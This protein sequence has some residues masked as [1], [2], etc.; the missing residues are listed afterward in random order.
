MSKNLYWKILLIV[1]LIGLAAFYVY[2]PKD[3]LKLGLDLAGGTSLVYEIDTQD[4]NRSERKGLAQRMIPILLRR[5]D[6][7]NVANIVMRPQGDTRIEIQ[8]P[9]SSAETRNKR[10]D[11]EKALQSLEK[12]NVNLLVIR[13][14]L[15]ADDASRQEAFS[16][17]AGDSAERKEILENLATAYDARKAKQDERNS[18]ASQMAEIKEKIKSAGLRDDFVEAMAPQWSKLDVGARTEAIAKFVETNKPADEGLI[19]TLAGFFEDNKKLV[20]EYVGAYSK[21][22]EVVN[23]L[24]GPETGLNAQYDQAVA[25]LSELNLSMVQMMDVLDLSPDS[26]QRRTQFN[27]F[28]LKFPKRETKINAVISTFDEYRKDRGR[29]DDPE[30]LKRMLKGAGVLEFRILPASNDG[31]IT[32]G[33]LEGYKESLQTKGPKQALGGKYVW[34]Q[35]EEPSDFPT[36]FRDIGQPAVGTFGDKY[37]VLASNRQNECMLR[38]SGMKEWKLRRAYPTTDSKTGRRAIGFTHDEI[39]AGMFYNVTNSNIG[40]PLCIL[41][42]GVAISS[43][44]IN[45]AIRSSGVITGDFTETEVDDMVNKLN[46]G[47]F[48]ARLSEVPISE[49][50]IGATIGVDNRN[51]GIGAGLIG[52]AA[53]GV[54]MLVYYLLAGSIADVALL[55]NM[56]FVLGMMAMFRGTFTLPG[57]AAIILTIGM[58]VD[59]NVLIFERIREEQDRGSSL[60]AAIATGYQRAFRTI[61]DANVTTLITALILYMVASEEIK[62]FAIVLMLGIASSMFTALFVTRMIFDF[63]V[64]KRVIK[65]H[66]L[67]L[68]L[69]RSPQVNWMGIRGV[70]FTIS[71]VLIAGGLAVFFTRNDAENSKYDIEFTGG[72]SIQ[73]DLKE[74]TGLT[75]SDIERNIREKGEELGNA[76]LRAAKVYSIG[77]TGLQ[78]EIS[79][80]ETNETRATVR[81]NEPGKETI[82]SVTEAVNRATEDG[83]GTLYNL[84][85]SGQ[86]QDFVVSTS[87]VNRQLVRDILNKAFAEKAEVSEPVVNEIVSRAVRESFSNYLDVQENL[88]V[89]IESAEKVTESDV[90][91]ADYLGGI[92]INCRLENGAT[93]NDIETRF[94]NIRFKPDMQYLVWY[95]HKILSSDLVEPEAG[96]STRSFVYVSVHP[97]AGYRQLSDDEWTRFVENERAKIINACSLQTSLAR[98]TQI[99][100]S[101][102]AQ[103]KTQAMVAII[104]SLVAIVGYI[105][106]RFGTARYGFAAIAALVHDVC[107]TLGAVTVCTYIASTGLGRALLISDFKIN[108]EMIAAF[109]TIIGYSLNDTIVVF[110]RIRENRGKSG[111]LT[112]KMISDS[113][114]QTLSRTLLTSVTTFMVVLVMYIWGG[115]GLRGFTFAMLVGIVIGTY[116]SIA[117]AA[118]IL[119]LGGKTPPS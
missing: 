31:K 24:T 78:Y 16:R 40:R 65:E 56:L 66:L 9:V 37:Y 81:F 48:P 44:V 35:I 83:S 114:N 104:L 46:A 11:Y 23:D 70:F 39:A 92:K 117:I 34:C 88:G 107:I 116:S 29:L 68:R 115:A 109:L 6:P 95:G 32:T 2:P 108:L 42:D 110:D 57:I 8:L 7:T 82:A 98:V 30:D 91:L 47:S 67:M 103:S 99:D 53:V 76:G 10:Q 105:W 41:L 84:S 19:E 60:R 64:V 1:V 50:S 71:L 4:L 27:D 25:R 106:V 85:V 87:Q 75:R 38:G 61:F 43:P 18:L 12:A 14:A 119:L 93:Y 55:L 5:I 74:G 59:A 72:T 52:L 90:E 97:E 94:G 101:I 112:P 45:D 54:F 3:K 36:S 102:G 79:T 86:G 111:K 77:D 17:F 20:E 113:I 58:S 62:G 28:V 15:L 73:I 118:P 21:W 22:A 33:E 13:R 89:T 63:L 80:T 51:Q 100:P 26:A 49:K 96:E 69:I